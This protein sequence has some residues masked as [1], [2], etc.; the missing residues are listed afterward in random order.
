MT[1]YRR[2]YVTGGLDAFYFR[3]NMFLVKYQLISNIGRI[4]HLPLMI[5][6]GGHDVVAPPEAA[7]LV[8]QDL[9]GVCPVYRP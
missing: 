1:G 9:T 7:C 5:V 4:A 8:P 3:N 6:Q 2:L